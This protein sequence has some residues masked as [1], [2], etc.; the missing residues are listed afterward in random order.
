[1]ICFIT[2]SLRHGI[3]WEYYTPNDCR[4]WVFW[5]G[6]FMLEIEPLPNPAD[7]LEARLPLMAIL[8]YASAIV[9]ILF[10]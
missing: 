9:G 1:M 7:L 4:L 2:K 6:R 3:I 10:F 5:V 8:T